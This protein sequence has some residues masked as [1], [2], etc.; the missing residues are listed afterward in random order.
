MEL[1]Y[2]YQSTPSYNNDLISNHFF[3]R[4]LQGQ[5][6]WWSCPNCNL[7]RRW[8]WWFR[9]WCQIRRRSCIPSW[10]R[11][12]V[13]QFLQTCTQICSWTPSCQTS[14]NTSLCFYQYLRTP[15]QFLKIF[16]NKSLDLSSP[17]SSF[18]I[19]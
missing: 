7:Y 3:F 10:T 14:I 15:Q 11:R 19:P 17:P 16:K 4:Y 12:R 6:S 8:L 2:V 13:W 1:L 5:P 9:R 18:K